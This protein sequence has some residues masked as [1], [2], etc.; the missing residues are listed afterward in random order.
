MLDTSKLTLEQARAIIQAAGQLDA[1]NVLKSSVDRPAEVQKIT[2][3]LSTARTSSNPMKVSIPFRSI[4]VR[5]AT[6][7][8]ASVE[9]R[10]NS[11]DSFQSAIPLKIND[12]F[13]FPIQQSQGYLT[14]EAQAGKTMDLYF[15]V[16]GEFRS[17][18]QISQTGGGVAIVDGS[19]FTRSVTTLV[20]ATATAILAADTSRKICSIQNNTG[21][22]LYVGDSAITS[23]GATRGYEV[24]AG[25]TFQ[26]RNTAA[27][28]AYS[29]GG[30]DITLLTEF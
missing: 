26:W 30:G 14:W 13:A 12:S 27:L 21:S 2:L 20:A 28:Y 5:A 15:F 8:L 25:A 19:A 10:P 9:L 29:V 11:V 16:S 23:S 7:V 6:D 24:P 3:D 4:F 17:G 22:T 18:S 1:A